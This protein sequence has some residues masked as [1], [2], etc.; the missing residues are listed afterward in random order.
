[1]IQINR[2]ILGR[3][4][5]EAVLNTLRS[6]ELTNPTY[7][8][9]KNVASAERELAEYL[10]VRHVVLVNSGTAAL[11]AA[12]LA[13]NI[14][15]GDEVLL[16]SFTFAATA[17]AVL[18]VNAKPIFV[19]ILLDDYCIDPEDLERKITPRC[20]AVIPVHLYGHPADMQ[21]VLEVARAHNLYV[22][23][24]AAQSLGATYKSK[25]TGS[26]GDIGCF[27]F[28]PSKVITSGE[29]G[30][31]ATDSCELADRVRM[32]RNHGLNTEGFVAR[33]GLN[34]RMNELSAAVLSAQ[35]KKLNQFLGRR[36]CNAEALSRML[37][38]CDAILPIELEGRR[39]N[40]YL[41]TVRV[42]NRD[43]VLAHLHQSNIGAA[44]Y[45][46]TPIHLQPSYQK[47]LGDV[48]L[49]KT[50]QAASEVISLPVHPAVSMAELKH[51]A[52]S[53]RSAL[54]N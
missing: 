8:G 16:P 27:S 23:E 35:L 40:W 30:A 5:E 31:V 41:Y 20:K 24:D 49:P 9:G 52:A 18:A 14:G 13:L 15:E 53:L 28:Y 36:R 7:Q 51:I 32:I 34:L 19:D 33:M 22:I 45:Y 47:L 46:K 26:L 1:M 2:P 21:R 44:V 54:P 12:L 39:S 11:H 43:K 50:E 3:E 29:G 48:R 4:E 37:E 25:Q 17:N 38:G 10:G 6:G 42:K